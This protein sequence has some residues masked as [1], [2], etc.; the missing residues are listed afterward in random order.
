MKTKIRYTIIAAVLLGLVAAPARAGDE[1][2]AAIGG[3]IAGIITGAVID[4]HDDHYW[5]SRHHNDVRVEVVR[6]S[7]GHYSYGY[8]DKYRSRHSRGHYTYQTVKIWVPGHY[9]YTRN[10]CGDRIRI[11]KSGYYRYEKRKVYVPYGH[12]R[13]LGHRR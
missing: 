1:A 11:W 4:D 5:H 7:R 2:V 12:Y 10:R 13:G 9:V 6:H 8:H 3:F